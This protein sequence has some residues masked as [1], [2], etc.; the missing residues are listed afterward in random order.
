ML[1]LGPL[2]LPWTPVLL[3]LGYALAQGVAALA[4]ARASAATASASA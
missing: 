4:R 1:R 2:L 3:A